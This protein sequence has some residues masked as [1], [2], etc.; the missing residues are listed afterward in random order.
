MT[1]YDFGV[2]RARYAILKKLKLVCLLLTCF[3]FMPVVRADE[4]SSAPEY[5]I[6][7]WRHSHF[8]LD[9]SGSL[10]PEQRKGE[11][12]YKVREGKYVFT[13]DFAKSRTALVV[14]DPWEDSGSPVM[15]RHIKKVYTQ[16]LVPLVKHA[17]AMGLKVVIVTNDPTTINLGYA[18]RIQPALQSVVDSGGAQVVYHTDM[19]DRKFEAYLKGVGIDTLIYTGFSS[20][21]CVI[22]MPTGMIPMFH[23]GFKLFFVPEASAA[24]EYGNTWGSGAAHKATTT[25]ISSWV[26]EIIAFKDFMKIK[27]I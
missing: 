1:V 7:A 13:R 5:Q 26:G 6:K 24:T 4:K 21:M 2:V 18:S 16:K 15:N 25:L 10:I 8:A 3:I 14:M 19:D 20:N 12:F 22:G 23:R 11:N 9:K 17:V 27:P